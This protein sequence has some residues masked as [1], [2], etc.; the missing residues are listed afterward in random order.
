MGVAEDWDLEKALRSQRA[1]LSGPLLPT[2]GW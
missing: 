2:L 1:A